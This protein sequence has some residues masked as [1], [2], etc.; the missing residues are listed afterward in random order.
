MSDTDFCTARE[1]QEVHKAA[2]MKRARTLLL[3]AALRNL[4]AGIDCF[5][6]DDIPEGIRFDGDGIVGSAVKSLAVANISE[7]YQGGNP[8][9]GIRDGRRRSHRTAANGRW[10]NVWRLKSRSVAENWLIE[11]GA[12]LTPRQGEFWP[13]GRMT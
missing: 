7:R 5:G 13:S 12:D 1:R 8:A 6:P 10:V 9:L 11:N 2:E 4:D 3:Q